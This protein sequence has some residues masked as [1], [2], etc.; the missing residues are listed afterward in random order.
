MSQATWNQEIF[1]FENYKV[2]W[3]SKQVLKP[4]NAFVSLFTPVLH[5]LQGKL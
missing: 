5:P 4:S 3:K 1:I 2:F